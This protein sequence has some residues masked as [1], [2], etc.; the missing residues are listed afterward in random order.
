MDREL[1]CPFHGNG[2][3]DAMPRLND[4]VHL[5][6]SSVAAKLQECFIA[7]DTAAST[8]P[9]GG[10]Q[11]ICRHRFTNCIPCSCTL[12]ALIFFRTIQ[13]P[14]AE[15]IRRDA[16]PSDSTTSH[17]SRQVYRSSGMH[18]GSNDESPRKIICFGTFNNGSNHAGRCGCTFNQILCYAGKNRMHG[19]LYTH[20]E[21]VTSKKIG[22]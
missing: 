16:D 15:R 17:G 11:H 21:A 10:I 20:P 12:K 8:N 14:S 5:R 19:R 6:A 1:P 13:H 3:S 22:L 7:L 18:A 4:V 2:T 9:P